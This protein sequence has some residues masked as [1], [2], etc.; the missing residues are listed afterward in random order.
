MVPIVIVAG[1]EGAEV[2]T[3]RCRPRWE[4]CVGIAVMTS[5]RCRCKYLRAG[6][7][8]RVG[9]N[10]P[11]LGGGHRRG[12]GCGVRIGGLGMVMGASVVVLPIS[13]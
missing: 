9:I 7:V 6:R 1:G 5:G 4:Y 10:T 8:K 12:A 3:G 2:A 13:P 11:G